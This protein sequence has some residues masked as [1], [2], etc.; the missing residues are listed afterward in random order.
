MHRNQLLRHTATKCA[1]AALRLIKTQRDVTTL[2]LLI[3]ASLESHIL[4][5]H[6]PL[7]PI[8]LCRLRD[9]DALHSDFLMLLIDQIVHL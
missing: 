9:D 3:D 5:R 1:L 6:F 8:S 7:C 2:A 4:G